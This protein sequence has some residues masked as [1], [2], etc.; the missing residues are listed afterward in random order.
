M[1]FDST[2]REVLGE[3]GFN[4]PKTLH[5]RRENYP[6]KR[7]APSEQFLKHGV[8][9]RQKSPNS[10]SFVWDK[11]KTI[12]AWDQAIAAKGRVIE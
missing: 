4:D 7:I 11:A 3:L 5:R 6:D 8:H 10:T 12:A 1:P 2:T 9:F